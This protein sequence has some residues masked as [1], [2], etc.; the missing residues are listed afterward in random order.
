I[1]TKLRAVADELDAEAVA[2]ALDGRADPALLARTDRR[3]A[4]L[5]DLLWQTDEVRLERPEPADEARNAVYYLADLAADAAPAV[6]DDLTT[7]LDDLGVAVPP[8]ARP[9]TFGS[10][11][12]GEPPRHP[13]VAPAVPRESLIIHHESRIPT[14]RR[15]VSRRPD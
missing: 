12:G 9:L 6:L 5:L 3:L 8:A 7:T 1:L 13:Y 11:I 14:R 4:E 10:W 2:G 15:V